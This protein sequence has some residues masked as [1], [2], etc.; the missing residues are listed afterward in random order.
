MKAVVHRCYGSPD[1]IRLE[2][3]EK[4]IPADNEVLVK[5]RAASVNALDWRSLRGEALRHAAGWRLRVAGQRG[6]RR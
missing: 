3:V 2:E 5:I 4:P 6:P 1:V